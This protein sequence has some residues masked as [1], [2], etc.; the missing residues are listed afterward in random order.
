[1]SLNSDA[2]FWLDRTDDLV[3]NAL[4]CG[5]TVQQ[6][7]RA[8]E[9]A[10]PAAAKAKGVTLRP[11]ADIVAEKREPRW[12]LPDV[13]E[14]GVL[15]VLAG[16]RGSFKS[17]VALHWLMR[18]AVAGHGVVILSGEGAGLD[19]RVAAW[20]QS[21]AP[22]M[23]LAALKVV[24]LEQPLNLNAAAT[25]A[26]LVAGINALPW[27]PDVV[28]ID[29][30]SKFAAGIDENDNGEV[31]AF[32]ASLSADL[33]DSFD[34]S[35]LLVA[36]AGHGDAARPRGASA[37]MANPDAEYIVKRPDATGMAVSVS[38]E[39]FKDSPSLP[40]LNYV[41]RS[42]DLGRLDSRGKPVC[43]LVLDS[44]DAPAMDLPKRIGRGRNQ[45]RAIS[46]LAEW[47]R[48]NRDAGH[49]SS[50]DMKAVLEGQSI[51]HRGRRGDAI[52]YLM[53][54]GAITNAVG[55][56]TVNREALA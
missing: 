56:F 24:A 13:L 2:K 28:L 53:S 32:L 46:A 43:S 11:V 36:H 9:A 5:A 22:G 42:V 1:M 30:F 4:N 45:E 26:E 48:V 17:F 15:A 10:L 14:A 38:R 31:A 29:T 27:K 54:V 49:I 25:R 6:V 51:R 8:V 12:L 34:C 37:L 47:A 23:D 21:F 33:R 52:A 55:G 50:I 35:V 19:R 44:V 40:P 7:R 41:A 3:A 18:A 39:R 20:M 16:P